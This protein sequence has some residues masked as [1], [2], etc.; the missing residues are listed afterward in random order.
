MHGPERIR[1]VAPGDLGD[2]SLIHLA[3]HTSIIPPEKITGGDHIELLYAPRERSYLEPLDTGKSNGVYFDR[4]KKL[5]QIVPE[6]PH[7]FEYYHDMVLFRQM[8]MPL[9][10][11]IGRD[12]ELY[13]QVGVDHIAS[14]SFPRYD[15]Y[16]YGMNTFVLARAL[17]RGKG[18]DEDLRD[19]CDALYGPDAGGLMN[20]YFVALGQLCATTMDTNDYDGFT[21]LRVMPPDQP[22]AVLHRDRLAP[23]V[24]DENLARVE[25]LLH[26]AM[27]RAKSPWR[28]RVEQ[29]WPLWQMAR[30]ETVSIYEGIDAVTKMDAALKTPLDSKERLDLIAQLED[31]IARVQRGTA[32]LLSI[33]ETWKGGRLT[34]EDPALHERDNVDLISQ[35]AAIERLKKEVTP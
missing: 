32:I 16:A 28:E 21:D 33:P 25:G 26:E 11:V 1:P 12:V 34:A 17:W 2:T 13:R 29:Q 10:S 31:S 20:D 24:S 23:L 35:K 15:C 18:S 5:I 8:P 30:M 7:V 9:P 22:G 3:Y 14:L 6:H 19:Y 4:L 27:M